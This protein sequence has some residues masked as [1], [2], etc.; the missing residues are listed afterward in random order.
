MLLPTSFPYGYWHG[1][2]PALPHTAA[3]D[4][5]RKTTTR[6]AAIE[7]RNADKN[8]PVLPSYEFTATECA[9]DNMVN[10]VSLLCKQLGS[11]E[12]R[13]NRGAIILHSQF[14][15]KHKHWMCTR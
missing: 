9:N 4:A 11:S 5:R 8:Q 13:F 14:L 10:N 7:E 2:Q 6:S 12:W 1:G 15:V 3:F